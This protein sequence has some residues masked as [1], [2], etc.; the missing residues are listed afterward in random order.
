MIKEMDNTLYT[1]VDIL[2]T[3]KDNLVMD[4]NIMQ[5]QV[6]QHHFV[7]SRPIC[8]QKFGLNFYAPCTIR[9]CIGH[10]PTSLL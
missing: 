9:Q 1:K 7:H 2:H 10:V 8:D 4:Q 3:L 6:D 5:Q